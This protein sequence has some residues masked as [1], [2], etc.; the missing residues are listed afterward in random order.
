M[1]TQDYDEGM[2]AWNEYYGQAS[3]NSEVSNGGYSGDSTLSGSW[4][5]KLQPYVKSGNADST[6]AAYA[7]N[8]GVWHCPDAGSQK[9]QVYVNQYSGVNNNQYS[10]SYG[11]NAEVT[12]TNY[13]NL[14][15]VPGSTAVPAYYRYPKITEMDEPASTVYVGDGGGYNSRI[16]APETFNCYAKRVMK[17]TSLPS[18]TYREECW[19]V[20]DRHDGGSSYVFCDGHAKYFP[21]SIVYPIP[22]NPLAPTT[23]EKQQAYAASAKY[24][25]YN[26][27]DRAVYANAAGIAVP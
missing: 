1:Y 12:Y 27:S 16:A 17:T 24:F 14:D 23:A 10:Y 19:E 6:N 8:D 4:Q 2:P 21:A 22:V 13:C 9:E 20:P 11:M 3:Y 7:N 15:G 25:A 26:A 18:G 5:A